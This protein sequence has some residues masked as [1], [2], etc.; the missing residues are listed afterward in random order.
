[1]PPAWR[2]PRR[3]APGLR[4]SPPLPWGAS[5]AAS[6]C[7]CPKAPP[8]A[9]SPTVSG[10]GAAMAARSPL[11]GGCGSW[12]PAVGEFP[13]PYPG[14]SGSPCP[15]FCPSRPPLTSDFGGR[16]GP[17]LPARAWARG[18][19]DA[20]PAASGSC[21]EPNQRKASAVAATTAS[22][23]RVST[24]L[25]QSSSPSPSQPQPGPAG[26]ASPWIMVPGRRPGAAC[27]PHE[28]ALQSGLAAVGPDG[29]T[30]HPAQHAAR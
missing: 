12:V 10:A 2:L 9:T 21:P 11:P 30:E 25:S 15:E 7:C 18:P 23:S 28:P 20:G 19:V 29:T 3:A 16:A 14:R 1:M 6:P 8:L 26:S 13:W 24:A 17:A 27:A 22:A 5:G 4:R